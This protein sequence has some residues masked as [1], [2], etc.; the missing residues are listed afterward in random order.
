MENST[1]LSPEEDGFIP[2][3]AEWD[4]NEWETCTDTDLHAV[5][6]DP[7]LGPTLVVSSEE[8]NEKSRRESEKQALAQLDKARL[9]PVAFAVCTNVAYDGSIDD[10][11]PVHGCAVSFKIKDYLHIK[12]KFNTDWWIGR[13]VM[14]GADIGFIPSPA[15]LES[16]R[17][18]QNSQSQPKPARYASRMTSSS[19]VDNLLHSKS[20]SSQ[21]SSPSTDQAGLDGN[22]DDSESLGN[23]HPVQNNITPGGRDRR[24]TFFKKI[25]S[26]QPYEV[27]PS[28]RPVVFIGP[29]LKGYEVTDMLQKALFDFLK[30]KFENRITITRVTADISLAKRSLLNN[31]GKRAILERSNSRS[32]SIVEVQGEIERI[33]ELARTLQ[34]VVLD[35]DTI[36]HPSQL[37]KTSLSPIQVFIRIS[38]PKVLQKLIKMRSQATR[39]VLNVQMVASEKLNQCPEE[40]FDIVLE[41]TQLDEACEHLA[42][43]LEAYWRATHPPLISSSQTASL[44]PSHSLHLPNLHGSRMSINRHSSTIRER[45]RE[46]SMDRRG[47]HHRGSN[48]GPLQQTR[49]REQHIQLPNRNS[50]DNRKFQNDSNIQSSYECLELD[51]RFPDH[52]QEKQTEQQIGIG[53]RDQHAMKRESF[54]V[55]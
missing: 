33:F 9:K 53:Y 37:S 17:I 22:G 35:C 21:G 16:L 52:I 4:F 13:Q 41:E 47:S 44:H 24:K 7:G 39:N 2:P 10:D 43:Y 51:M 1:P 11:S 46:R 36:N 19:N 14:E 27:V 20:S 12:E 54:R 48:I 55:N 23:R 15:K 42:D 40:L 32:T 31:P 29:S 18:L 49:Q 25:E 45:S 30:H 50:Q 38:S 6:S 8:G 34:L 26:V 5:S 3:W 28:M